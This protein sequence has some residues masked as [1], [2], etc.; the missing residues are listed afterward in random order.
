MLSLLDHPGFKQ[1]AMPLSVK[2]WHQMIETG[3][4][5][6]KAELIRGVIVEKMSKSILHTKL[7]DLLAELLRDSVPKAFWIRQEAPLTFA[8][9]EPEPDVSVVE[10]RRADYHAHPTTARLVVEV[11]VSSLSE[12]RTLAPLYAEAAVAEYWIVNGK[13]RCIEVYRD[14]VNGKYQTQVR[15]AEGGVLECMSLPG[16]SVSVSELFAGIDG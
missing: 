13:E 11:S 3:L 16:V 8:D 6:D 9:S 7:A 12:D 1:R 5:P 2:V 4:A 15:V 10:G 14:A